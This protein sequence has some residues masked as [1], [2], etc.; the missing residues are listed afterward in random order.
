M[1]T[2]VIGFYGKCQKFKCK[3]LIPVAV[4][5]H[6]HFIWRWQAVYWHDAI[7]GA[8]LTLEHNVSITC[9]CNVLVHRVVVAVFWQQGGLWLSK[10]VMLVKNGVLYYFPC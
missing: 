7:Y 9:I 8:L 6:V 1:W 5:A 10:T 3:K 2:A 4:W